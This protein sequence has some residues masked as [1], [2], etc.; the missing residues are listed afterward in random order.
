MLTKYGKRGN[1]PR[2]LAAYRLVMGGGLRSAQAAKI[3]DMHPV[4]VSQSLKDMGRM[5]LQNKEFNEL[6]DNIEKE[7]IN[8]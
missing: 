3:L 2:K 6:F 5:R 7:I 4:R 1:W 8:C